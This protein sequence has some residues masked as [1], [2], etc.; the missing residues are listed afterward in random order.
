MAN[1]KNTF[2]RVAKQGGKSLGVDFNGAIRKG[3]K[4]VPASVKGGAFFA[5]VAA[6]ILLVVLALGAAVYINATKVETFDALLLK[7]VDCQGLGTDEASLHSLAKETMAYL[8]DVQST[9]EPQITLSG[10]PV[11]SFIPQSFRDHME[12]V[13]SGLRI[14]KNALL[15]GAG[16]ALALLFGVMGRAKGKKQS[17]F[18]AGGYYLGVGVGLAIIAGIAL[19]AFLDFESLWRILHEAF[20]PDGIFNAAEPIM[21]FFPVEMFAGYMMPVGSAFGL[22]IAA[23]LVLPLVLRPLSDKMAGR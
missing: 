19:W 3:K 18:S 4:P 12:T 10:F 8:T 13:K 1:Q 11:S 17:R 7:H 2:T 22:L 16:I 21:A 6:G 20:I 5:C 14:A 23:V 15:A 9:W